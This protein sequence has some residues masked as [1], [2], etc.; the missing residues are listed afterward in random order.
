MDGLLLTREYGHCVPARGPEQMVEAA[1]AHVCEFTLRTQFGGLAYWKFPFV[2]NAF[3]VA[4][5]SVV[6]KE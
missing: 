4:R 1:H 5:T 2:R 3:V 6:S